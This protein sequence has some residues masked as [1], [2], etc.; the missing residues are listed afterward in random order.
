M[1]K[2][3]SSNHRQTVMSVFCL[4]MNSGPVSGMTWDFFYRDYLRLFCVKY[5]GHYFMS[6]FS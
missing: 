5:Y 2:M 6:G 4:Y 3:K 1:N